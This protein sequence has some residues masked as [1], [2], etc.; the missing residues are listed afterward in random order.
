MIQEHNGTCLWTQL[1]SCKGLILTL[2]TSRSTELAAYLS[3]DCIGT[4]LAAHLS[5]DCI[6]TEGALV[7]RKPLDKDRQLCGLLTWL[8]SFHW[9]R[10]RHQ[11]YSTGEQG[12]GPRL[13]AAD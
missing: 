7:R 8:L 12:E 13:I 6:G 9:P 10:A 2:A 4:E 5:L 11:D 1:G 3:L